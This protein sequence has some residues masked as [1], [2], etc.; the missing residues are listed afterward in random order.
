METTQLTNQV[1]IL[2]T[3][4]NKFFWFSVIL[5][6]YLQIGNAI[7]CSYIHESFGGGSFWPIIDY[8]NN[9]DKK[10]YSVFNDYIA[11]N[12]SP[13]YDQS[14]WSDKLCAYRWELI[15]AMNLWLLLAI[16]LIG[17]VF[18]LFPYNCQKLPRLLR[19][20][21]KPV[22]LLMLLLP[23]LILWSYLLIV[24]SLFPLLSPSSLLCIILIAI[25]IRAGYIYVASL[26]QRKPSR[27]WAIATKAN[28]IAAATAR[29]ADKATDTLEE[30]S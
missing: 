8:K 9:A 30:E 6:L 22:P 10:N 3:L 13:G 28:S 29:T 1:L 21:T 25:S 7:F 16:S 17:V 18:F 23:P 27:Q 20:L 2:N 26:N 15:D 12:F 14:L 4:K 11:K 24:D 5:K 19:P